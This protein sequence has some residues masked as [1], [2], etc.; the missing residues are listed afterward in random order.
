MKINWRTMNK[1]YRK[2]NTNFF[3]IENF[4]KKKNYD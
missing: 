3:E 1:F 4:K 2:I